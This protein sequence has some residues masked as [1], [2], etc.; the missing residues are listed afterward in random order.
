MSRYK[1]LIL[2]LYLC[3]LLATRI[4]AQSKADSG[5]EK[6]TSTPTIDVTELNISDKTLKLCYEIKNDSEHDIWICENI[7]VNLHES[8]FEAY[9]AEDKQTLLIRRRLDIEAVGSSPYAP[10]RGRYVR[11]R[12]GQ[13]RTESL[14][15]S[16][17]V[18][19]RFFWASPTKPGKAYAK[20][21][22][23]EIGYY[24]GDMPGMIRGILEKAEKYRG[25]K[26]VVY[27]TYP[28]TIKDWFHSLLLFNMYNLPNKL[29]GHMGEEIVIPWTGQFRMG[30]QV[31]RIT[32]D[33]LRIPYEEKYSL[34]KV[35][36][37]DL[38]NCTRLEI[39]YRPSVLDYFFPYPNERDLLSAEEV[40]YLQSLQ[41]IV[42]DNQERL[43][44]FAHEVSE[45]LAGGIYTERS[46][47]RV[48]CY[49][50]G[51]RL[52]SFTIYDDR[53]IVTEEEQCL[54]YN[55]GLP[56][57][58]TLTKQ[59]QPFHLRLECA[60]NLRNLWTL[61]Q[62]LYRSRKTYPA[63][64]WCASIVRDRRADDISTEY[65]MRFFKCLA[66]GEGKCHYAMNRNCKPNSPP[67]MVLLF[68]AKAGWNQHGGP[69]LFT[70]DN[71]DPKGGC[72]LL[73][74]GTVK[75][76]RTKQELQQLKWK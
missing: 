43:K 9:M 59:I 44:E 35:S 33:G 47:A 53:S 22:A 21:L 75:F 49:R 1:S 76:I 48:I 36:P 31:S 54:R 26:P 67:D 14:F 4:Q 17:P 45:G 19:S 37:P 52:S 7:S 61:L 65:K 13:S 8:D 64:K 56:S 16:L 2:I 68:E 6:K 57:L 63:S 12:A 39:W 51:E 25:T 74:D 41:K 58:K 24:P 62:F 15:L 71:H 66:A 38:N 18:E 10:P 40:K 11:L 29:V 69:E 50:D 60:D 55:I 32:I 5:V 28:S 46:T 42:A 70:F 72:V 23:L 30:E 34:P 3:I 20:S 27:P 73:N